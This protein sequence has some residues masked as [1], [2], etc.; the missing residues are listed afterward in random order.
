[1]RAGVQAFLV[2]HTHWDREW[3]MTREKSRYMLVGLM[4]ELFTLLDEDP[5]YTFMLDGQTI[6]IQDYLEARPDRKG[7]LASHVASG[8]ISIGPWYV[9]P[10]EL[11]ISGESHI[12]NYL[13]G[14][15]QCES[16]AGPMNIGYLPTPSATL[17][18][19]RRS[20][21]AWA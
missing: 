8:R 7:L 21:P 13:E 20:L 14:Q 4:E 12:R 9:L 18:S 2:S 17:P 16:S 3:Y 19:S 15:R 11:L 5:E 10:D 1:M 6:A